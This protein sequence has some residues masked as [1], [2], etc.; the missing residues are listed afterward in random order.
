[1]LAKSQVAK[2]IQIVLSACSNCKYT[3]PDNFNGFRLTR[4][5]LQMLHLTSLS[6]ANEF[7]GNVNWNDTLHRTKNCVGFKPVLKEKESYDQQT[8][9]N[10]VDYDNPDGSPQV[11]LT[12]KKSKCSNFYSSIGLNAEPLE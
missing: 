2:C 8:D 4:L 10:T 1:M 11:A 6:I 9:K 7:F 3:A 12:N 5:C